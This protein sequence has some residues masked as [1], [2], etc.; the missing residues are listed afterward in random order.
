MQT[1]S[2]LYKDILA[3]P[4]HRYEVSL[5]IGESGLLLDTQGNYITF[6]LGSNIVR[7]LVDTGGAES[8]FNDTTLVSVKI[9]QNLFD[10]D[11]PK[12]GCAVSAEIDVEMIAPLTEVPKK[13]RIVPY[14]RVTNGTQTSEWIQQGVF[15]IDTREMTA[16]EGGVSVL[17]FHGYDKMVETDK[18]FPS[19]SSHDFP[20]T[21]TVI[22]QDIA[23]AIG[24]D[25]DSRT[26]TAMN[27]A[28]QIGLPV[29][30]SCRE[31][32]QY[33]AGAY[34]GNFIINE[35]GDLRLVS[36]NEM[37]QETNLLIDNLGYRIVF[38]SGENEV[39]ILV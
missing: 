28:Y 15:Y 30:Y 8:G 5:A 18:D 20:A 27:M 32:L 11:L 13:A 39:R 3:E 10:A 24:F 21:D 31:I 6:G 4:S 19:I 33:I 36:L 12:V 16:N 1:T 38:G 2:Q 26:W 37:P 22:V 9:S 35:S 7:L 23:E 25:V 34:C 29:G 17:K 14:V